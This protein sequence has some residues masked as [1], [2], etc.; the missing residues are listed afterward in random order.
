MMIVEVVEE[1]EEMDWESA[2]ARITNE[3]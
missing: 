3:T 1:V 2:I